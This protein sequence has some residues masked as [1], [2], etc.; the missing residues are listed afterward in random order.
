MVT[1]RDKAPMKLRFM[2]AAH[3]RDFLLK[4]LLDGG[5]LVADGVTR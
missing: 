4:R 3:K 1:A 2:R 5:K